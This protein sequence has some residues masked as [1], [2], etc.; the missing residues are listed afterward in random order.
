M[1]EYLVCERCGHI[2][3]DWGQDMVC[4]RCQGKMILVDISDRKKWRQINERSN[5]EPT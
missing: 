2:E 3:K 4:R 5:K 1:K